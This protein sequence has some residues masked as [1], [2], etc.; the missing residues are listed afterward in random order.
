MWLVWIE[1]PHT[2]LP[3]T[4]YI[5]ISAPIA[6]NHIAAHV[7][8]L[9]QLLGEGCM[10]LEV[11]NSGPNTGE[12]RSRKLIH[13]G[14]WGVAF[15]AVGIMFCAFLN[16]AVIWSSSDAFCGQFCH[17][18]NWASAAYKRGPHFQNAVGVPASCG[19]CHIPYD[20]HPGPVSHFIYLLGFKANRGAKDFYN[21]A[22]NT[23]NTKEEWEKRRPALAGEFEAFLKRHDYITCRG[24]HQINSFG[25]PNSV[26]KQ[27]IHA[28][29]LTP[30]DYNCLHCHSDIGHVYEEPTAAP[31]TA[32]ASAPAT[33][34][35]S[36]PVMTAAA[37]PSDWY[38]ADQAD[39]GSK[40][41]Q[42]NCSSCHGPK[43]EGGAGPALTGASWKQLFGGAKLL[44]V[45]GEVHGP[46]A[47]Y[48]GTTFTEQQSLDITAY[49]LQQNGY[50]AGSKP[51]NDTRS[52]SHVIPKN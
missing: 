24:C 11:S 26:M 2:G 42:N 41:Y 34:A 10:S 32:K 9:W 50:P 14:I 3:C 40:L 15:I 12:S 46:M 25:G 4:C 37:L 28:K 19:S 7:R 44:K 23:I 52:L 48:A 13:L 31:N 33:A 30:N 18:M 27:M 29:Y 16:H 22:L 43:L 6:F 20:S 45:W 51:L 21:E 5:C 39:A 35:P 17:S 47:Q 8:E 49:L 36:T 1:L 38:A